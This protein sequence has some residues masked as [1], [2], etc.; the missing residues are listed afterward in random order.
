MKT[1]GFGVV[2]CGYFGGEY[3][4]ILK[5]M[6]NVRIV[7][8]QG[9]SGRTANAIAEEVGCETEET[10]EALVGRE[11]IDV[12]VLASPSYAHKEGVIAAA[13]QGKHVFC[14]KPIALSY[15]DC[16]EMI[17]ACEKAGV[18]FMAGHILHFMHGIEKV[19]K[20]VAEGEIG[21]VIVCHAERTGWEERQQQI[22]WKKNNAYS[23]GHLFHHIHE[24]D[25]IQSIAG[26][27]VKVFTAGGNLAHKGEGFGDE[28]D[29][30]LLTMELEGG[31][32]ATMQY[33]S[34][35]RWGE[36]YV[37]I[38]GT[39]GAVLIDF[40]RSIVELKK[41]Y[42]TISFMLHEY[43]EENEERIK[44]Y[45]DMDGGVI[46]GNPSQR[47]NAYLSRMMEAE[48]SILR[49]AVAGEPIPPQYELLFNNRSARSSIHTA[50]SA[51]RAL[52]EQAWIEIK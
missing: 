11:D 16:N 21:R 6:D 15:A 42:R 5:G 52:K 24:L 45:R 37:K 19:K 39:E 46:Y 35:F 28:D 38:N 43:P 9:G 20:L 47:P 10:L 4:R 29:V 8:V 32:Y 48:M 7:A 26:P 13:R 14:E 33:G 1:L 34:G 18:R 30:L 51:M 25:L 49:D 17:E 3:A 31:A 50:E 23:G 12:V 41:D 2:G 40:K 36:H 22:S 44:L 27:A